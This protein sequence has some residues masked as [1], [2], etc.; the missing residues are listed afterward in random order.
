M[1]V[2]TLSLPASAP[3]RARGTARLVVRAED[4]RTRL[5]R[6]YQE[7]SAKLRLPRARGASLEAV[8]INSAGGM[9]GGDRFNWTVEAGAGAHA[10]L[11]TQA[12]ERVYRASADVARVDTGLTLGPGARLDWL[13]QETILFDGSALSRRI[14]ADLAPD[15]SLLLC[16]AVILGR[17]AM[18]ETFARGAFHDRWR[19]RR[20]G[21]LVFADDLRLEGDIPHLIHQ[22]ALLAG[23]GAFATLLLVAP[24]AAA[25]LDAVRQ[26]IDVLGG[27]L[28]GASAFDGK[29]VA[30]L[31]APDGLTLR[32]ALIP[33]L[34]A[35]GAAPPAVWTL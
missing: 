12:C 32:R 1:D 15:A 13:P 8:M 7:G 18:G 27:D 6:L 31:A 5:A 23:A 9:T 22:P 17:H 28:G 30:R 21:R 20:D 10:V 29:L 3:Q 19:V 33:A 2:A 25:R 26:A 11:T 4:G 14:T 35:L 24:D 34:A 16:E